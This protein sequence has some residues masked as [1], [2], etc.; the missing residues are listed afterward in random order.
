MVL[1]IP[2]TVQVGIEMSAGGQQL[3]NVIG[4]RWD[5]GFTSVADCLATVKTA[6]EKTG[7]PLSKLP[8][9]VTM[10]GYH[11]VFLGTADGATGFLGSGTVGGVAAE[12]STLASCAVVKLSGASRSRSK[13]G[14]LYFGP[15]PESYI[16]AD[17]RTL[18]AG[19]VT[20]MQAAFNIFINEINVGAR[21][22][23]VIS[24]KN[25]EATPI[26]STG[27]QGVLG[28]QRRRLR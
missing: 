7:G 17:G 24:R 6:W 22:W 12:V 11:G 9:I 8:A 14:R 5:D 18:N 19:Q 1:I 15:L 3:M 27:I 16:N 20:G 25:S 2:N 13:N 21:K 26:V 4:V 10:V 23:S 28:T